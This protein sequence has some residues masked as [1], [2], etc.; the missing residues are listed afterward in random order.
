MYE[1]NLSQC[2]CLY[3]CV[4]MCVSGHTISYEIQTMKLA[5][6]YCSCF[7]CN[8]VCLI[9]PLRGEMYTACNV[10]QYTYYAYTSLYL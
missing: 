2:V 7:P 1:F 9:H 3:A 5:H 10:V 4:W 8:C 6:Y